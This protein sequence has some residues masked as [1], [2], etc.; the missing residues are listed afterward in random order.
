MEIEFSGSGAISDAQTPVPDSLDNLRREA[1][2]SL[3]RT[4]V[5]LWISRRCIAAVLDVPAKERRER[6]LPCTLPSFATHA[7]PTRIVIGRRH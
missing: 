3:E 1:N 4:Q 7:H 2:D 6:R 5:K